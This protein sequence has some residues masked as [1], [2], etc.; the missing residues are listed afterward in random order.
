MLCWQH[1]GIQSKAD[2]L[3]PSDG[4]QDT[5]L[6]NTHYGLQLKRFLSPSTSDRLVTEGHH[7]RPQI[8]FKTTP[9]PP[10][11]LQL[12]LIT[13]APFAPH[14]LGPPKSCIFR[15]VTAEIQGGGFQ[16]CFSSVPGT[17]LFLVC[18]LSVP[19]KELLSVRR[20]T[21]GDLSPRADV[22]WAAPLYGSAAGLTRS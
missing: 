12:S 1:V 15:L 11:T 20:W 4:N 19:K 13:G 14:V 21:K 3:N 16:S 9:P 10:S 18:D 22:I 8:S 5:V 7:Q 17:C 2:L 6:I